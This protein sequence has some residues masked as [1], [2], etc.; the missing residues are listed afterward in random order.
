MR[1]A[2]ADWGGKFAVVLGAPVFG[3]GLTYAVHRS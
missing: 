2:I 1:G 3:G